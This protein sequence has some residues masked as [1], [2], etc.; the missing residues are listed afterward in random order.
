M[1]LRGASDCVFWF[2]VRRQPKPSPQGGRTQ[3]GVKGDGGAFGMVHRST[4]SNS[5]G[6]RVPDAISVRAS[7]RVMAQPIRYLFSL[8]HPGASF[9]HNIHETG[10]RPGPGRFQA[11]FRSVPRIHQAGS[12]PVFGLECPF[13]VDSSLIA[14]TSR[15]GLYSFPF[16]VAGWFRVRFGRHRRARRCDILSRPG[17]VKVQPGG[18]TAAAGIGE[19][20][21][22][23]SRPAGAPEISIADRSGSRVDFFTSGSWRS[24]F[25]DRI[26][27]RPSDR[28][29]LAKI[30]SHNPADG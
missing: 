26:R 3:A 2:S 25:D 19:F 30:S 21:G 14:L 8:A 13:C 23:S 24:F 18:G 16:S 20:G 5:W 1:T 11:G 27:R 4:L 10:S 29:R 6:Q 15:G 22:V 7:G 9:F 12:R 17:A 28:A